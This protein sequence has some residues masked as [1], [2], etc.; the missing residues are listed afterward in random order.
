MVLPALD[1][2]TVKVSVL[3]LDLVL[4]NAAVRR[5]PRDRVDAGRDQL[6]CATFAAAVLAGAGPTPSASQAA[7]DAP[8]P[9]ATPRA[10]TST[11]SSSATGCAS[12]AFSRAME[13]AVAAGDRA[14]EVRGAAVLERRCEHET[15]AM[16]GWSPVGR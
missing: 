11:T 15:V 2:E 6:T 8:G 3:M 16:A 14:L 12:E 9:R 5:R 7:L 1:D 13:A 10:S 4:R